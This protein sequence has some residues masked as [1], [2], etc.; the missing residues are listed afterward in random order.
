MISASTVRLTASITDGIHSAPNYHSNIDAHTSNCHSLGNPHPL[1]HPYT[2]G[3]PDTS[4][5]DSYSDG[6]ADDG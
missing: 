1:S 2:L 6:N 4:T 5:A 3:D